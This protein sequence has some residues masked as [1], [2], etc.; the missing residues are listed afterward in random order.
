MPQKKYQ[1]PGQHARTSQREQDRDNAS[2]QDMLR[3]I[4]EVD[5]PI[6]FQ[7]HDNS[8]GGSRGWG[9]PLVYVPVSPHIARPGGQMLLEYDWDKSANGE[10]QFRILEEVDDEKYAHDSIQ[11]RTNHQLCIACKDTLNRFCT[12]RKPPKDSPR[13]FNNVLH[14]ENLSSIFMSAGLQRCFICRQVLTKIKRMYPNLDK[15]A[16]SNYM[17]EC[18]W[19]LSDTKDETKMWMVMYDRN[20]EKRPI[21]N[22]QHILRLGLWNKKYFSSYFGKSSDQ[23]EAEDKSA[24]GDTN[25]HVGARDM[26]L[27]WLAR[28]IQ[29][30]D[31]QHDICNQKDQDYLPTR[32]LDVRHALDR[33]NVRLVIPDKKPEIFTKGVEY[34][35]LSHCWGANGAQENPMLLVA[36]LEGRQSE[37]LDWD[38]LPK[39]FQDAFNIASWLNLD[40]LWIDSMC[41]IQDSISDWQNEASMMDRVYMNAK[42]NI[43]ADKGG[44]SRAGCFTQRKETDITPL[45]FTVCRN[46]EEFMMT[47]ED[48]FGW[49]DTAPSLSRA[50]IHRE[51]QLSRRILHFTPKEM[52]W[53][54]CGL[55]TAC[56]ASETLPGGAPFKK[57]FNGETKFQVE[58]ADTSNNKLDELDRLDKLHKL[59]NTTCQD[60]SNKSITYAS[61]FPIILSSLAREFHRLMPN[62]E[63]V[64]GLWRSTLAEA[65]TWHVPGDKPDYSGYIAPSWSWLSIAEPIQLYHPSYKQRKRALIEVVDTELQYKSPAD[66]PY[67]QLSSGSALRVRGFLRRLHLHF[68]AH[69]NGGIILSVIEEDEHGQDRLRLISEDWDAE[70]GMAFRLTTDSALVL[71]FQEY[72]FYGLFTTIDEWAQYRSDCRRQIN[73]LM[74]EKVPGN[75]GEEDRYQRV[76]TLTNFND[77]VS[78]K[79][80]YQVVPEATGPE[81]G[82]SR[83]RWE[84]NPKGHTG[85]PIHGAS[86]VAPVE[87]E[88]ENSTEDVTDSKDDDMAKQDAETSSNGEDE[89]HELE[90]DDDIWWL[91]KEYLCWV[92][93]MIVR[94]AMEKEEEKKKTIEA[95]D[96]GESETKDGEDEATGG[97]EDEEEEEQEQVSTDTTGT[98]GREADIPPSIDDDE[99]KDETETTSAEI[100]DNLEKP[101]EPGNVVEEPEQ[102]SRAS[103]AASENGSIAEGNDRN[104]DSDK[105]DDDEEDEEDENDKD[106]E[107]QDSEEEDDEDEETKAKKDKAAEKLETLRQE[108]LTM[109]NIF[110]RLHEHPS[111]TLD[112]VLKAEDR[113]EAWSEARQRYFFLRSRTEAWGTHETPDL[114]AALYQFDDLLD[115]WRD[116]YDFVPW[117]RRLEVSEVVLI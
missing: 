19:S 111:T 16:Y 114:E 115:T 85:R 21:Y 26:A 82:V 3:Q 22:Y 49:M 79:L 46:E 62:D 74:L 25:D 4:R 99:T 38:R 110:L 92:R 78:F 41:I 42:V 77:L 50:W 5:M 27:S 96:S 23:A 89:A 34:A 68:T 28:C 8:F 103:P 37:G 72:E 65:L 61:D 43:S 58:L 11:L 17:I 86:Y 91:L 33:G 56:F 71:D 100:N 90:G 64:A 1:L 7:L 20:M 83:D 109:A 98:V 51:R 113:N 14:L 87:P 2:H 57:V 63:Y 93:W 60:L 39:T 53:E 31:G 112:S 76:G 95:S 15:D 81:A 55:N 12:F 97:E 9:E 105:G 107:D 52:V 6:M 44:D 80:R 73:C 30:V 75:G 94:D 116:K 13:I 106:D 101:A 59:W 36:N 67:G 102:A 70:E 117:L 35:S 18:C 66:N 54:C 84:E 88:Q 24:K 108:Y 45:E 40:W 69:E 104:E 10:P 32:I 29:N 47:T 48:T